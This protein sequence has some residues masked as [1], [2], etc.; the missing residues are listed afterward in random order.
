MS[1]DDKKH[2]PV[3]RGASGKKPAGSF[4]AKVRA[5]KVEKPPR[6]SGAGRVDRALIATAL[7]TSQSRP[8]LVFA[9]DATA[10][11]ESA[12][13]AAQATTDALFGAVPGELDVALAAHGGSRI[14]LFTE[15]VANAAT[16]RDSA[17]A[18]RC[19]AGTTQLIEI[20]E[21][22]R[23]AAGVKVL[24]YIGDVFEENLAKAEQVATSL[25][26]RGTRVVILHDHG[27]RDVGVEAFQRIAAITHGAVLPFDPSSVELLR[28][29]L[30]AVA[31]LAAGGVKLLETRARQLPA[32][33]L[34]LAQLPER[35]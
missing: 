27:G 9:I 2:L 20:M 3:K 31:T 35:T 15:F 10:S 30:T 22:C 34:L 26:L 1:P 5:A 28:D 18:L 7:A 6:G 23:S 8:R 32:A 16:L 21:R 19:E 13:T 4:L 25:R 24:L 12:W 29:L 33:R 17:A 14:K 11:R